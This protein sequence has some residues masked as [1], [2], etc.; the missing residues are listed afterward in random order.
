MKWP[1]FSLPH[2]GGDVMDRI[3]KIFRQSIAVKEDTLNQNLEKIRQAAGMLADA[4]HSGGKVLICGNGGS[5]ADSQHI[6]AEFIGR[7]QKERKALAAVALTTD[8]SILTALANDYNFDIVFS[9]QIEGLGQP[10][11]VLLG[12]STSG[13]SGNVVKAV[14]TAGAVGMKTIA[15]TGSG[16]GRLAQT[17]D[18]CIAVPSAVTARVQESH[19]L[20]AHVI[21]ELVEE[22][23]GA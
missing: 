11:D 22:G 3:Q 13:N 23:Y 5:A 4:F 14:E 6:A 20:V 7:F 18:L 9:R 2:K 1:G 16:G 17:A 19:L 8:S 12:I 21:C 10:G 15:L